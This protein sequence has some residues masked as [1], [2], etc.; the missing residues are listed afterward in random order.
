MANAKNIFDN[1]VF[2]NSD[3]QVSDPGLS[4]LG[5]GLK[6]LKSL[7]GMSLDFEYFWFKVLNHYRKTLS[8][9]FFISS[10]SESPCMLILNIKK[11]GASPFN[12]KR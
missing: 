3:T 2:E 7:T 9:G 11:S 5:T 4:A 6:E 10:A 1:D 12:V 8:H